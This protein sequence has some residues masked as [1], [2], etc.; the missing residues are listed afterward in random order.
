MNSRSIKS[1][2]VG[3]AVIAGATLSSIL[4]APAAN[5]DIRNEASVLCAAG[6]CKNNGPSWDVGF[7]NVTCANGL[8]APGIALVPPHGI[9]PLASAGCQQPRLYG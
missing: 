5:A 3:G 7:G 2:V 1:L 4:A 8:T 6:T 9:A